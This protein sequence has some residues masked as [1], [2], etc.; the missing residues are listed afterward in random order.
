MLENRANVRPLGQANGPSPHVSEPLPLNSSESNGAIEATSC[1]ADNDS[2]PSVE[3]TSQIASAVDFWWAIVRYV[4]YSVPS[5]PTV[6]S[7]NCSSERP[8]V[9]R[10]GLENVWP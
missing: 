1:G 8:G 4:T 2:P 6:A 7:A 5:G 10:T 3:R 9:I